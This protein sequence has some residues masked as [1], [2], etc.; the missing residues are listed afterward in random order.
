MD[1]KYIEQLLERYFDAE[2]TLQEEQIL[3][4]FFAQNVDEMPVALLQYA[5]LFVAL[6][7]RTADEDRLD[8][9][10]DERIL[11]LTEQAPVV[12][13][14]TVS[15]KERLKPL[16]RAAAVVAMLLTLSNALNQSFQEPDEPGRPA[17]NYA[18]YFEI[19]NDP[20]MA[21]EVGQRQ[22]SVLRDTLGMK[23]QKP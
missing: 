15:I 13:A 11:A 16:F 23:P 17:D 12:K 21:Y 3:K 10:F 20:A 7:T 5:P 9:S 18:G 22:D 2:T 6:G 4:S 14:R 8:D 19:S 1:Y